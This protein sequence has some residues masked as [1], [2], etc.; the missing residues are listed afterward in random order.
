MLPIAPDTLLLQRYRVLNI[1]EEGK[2]GRTYLATDRSRADAYCAIEE[3]VP[4]TELP[5]T[6][7]K[8]KA[9]FKQEATLLYRLQHLQVPR[10]WTV[11]EEQ[12]RFFLVRD[13][14]SGKTYGY[15]LE[16]R[17]GLGT[18]FSE[19][20]V[21]EFLLE[22]LPVIGYIHSKGVIHRDLSPEQI[23][24]RDD[25]R[26][27]ILIDFAAVREF[28]NKLQANP[29]IQSLPIGQP[30]YAP[31]EQLQQGQVY[32]N[33]DLYALAVTAIVL[34]T[35][36]EPSALF[37]GNLM[38]WDWRKWT[39]IDDDFAKILMRMLN[40]Q[41]KDRYQSAAEVDRDLQALGNPNFHIP[42]PEEVNANRPS[43]VPTVAIGGKSKSAPASGS[44]NP[45]QTAITQLNARSLWEKPQFFIPIGLVIA[46][47]T[48]LGSW[49]GV[50]QLLH[51]DSSSPTASTP[52]KQI[53]FNNPTIP[54]D[55]TTPSPTAG[56]IIQPAVDRPIV[57]E[58][59]VD[60]KNPVRY[61]ISALAGQNLDIQL[62]DPTSQTTDPAK[63]ISSP[64]GAISP[65][66][67][68]SKA[69]KTSSNP[70]IS[71]PSPIAPTQVLMTIL[72]PTGAAIDA[73]ADRVVGWRGQIPTSGEYTIELR[74]IVG[75]TGTTFPYKLS[76]TQVSASPSP[77]PSTDSTPINGASPSPG[78]SPS[79]SASPSTSITPSTGSTPPL[80]LPVPTT[81][82]SGS[83]PSPNTNTT[84]PSIAPS[85]VPIVVPT[86]TPAESERPKRTRRRRNRVETQSSPEVKQPSRVE[87]TEETT[88]TPRRRRKQVESSDETTTTPR[89]NRKQV[90]STE[91]TT[92]TPRRRR[93]R[94][95]SSEETTSTPRRNRDRQNNSET[96][97][98]P[99]PSASPETND[100]G[101]SSTPQPEPS[102]GIPVPPAKSTTPQPKTDSEST[103]T[104]S[105]GSSAIDPD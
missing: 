53:D 48:G 93:K 64:I 44:N 70:P 56:D 102:V 8:A 32:P 36:K 89:R 76:V 38:N 18:V 83:N 55:S 79:P 58:G 39:H 31:P 92:P 69:P 85:P 26:L 96:K 30:G 1:L 86:T 97:P 17:R 6:L 80:S 37:A 91:E 77:S 5:G 54:T 23:L 9:F 42:S 15:L 14:I 68:Q 21:R 101:S 99:S 34:L 25:D 87:S 35:G 20:E 33:S 41:P 72:S 78:V 67:S 46:L 90:E 82:G 22:V 104:P 19:T 61:R 43:T 65:S 27:P 98:K 49:F 62:A 40:L 57:K 88:T 16:E 47:L 29:A 3:I 2:L 7:A 75:L 52:P 81:T 84:T 73:Q 100:S 4:G 60:A 71:V 59:T 95:E 28:A 24:Q 51:R 13:Y 74:P 45:V 11:F 103:T 105:P 10:F 12:N 94:V 63:S 50:T 66:P